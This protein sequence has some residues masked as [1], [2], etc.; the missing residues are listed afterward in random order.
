MT[1]DETSEETSDEEEK[2]QGRTGDD[3]PTIP[4][5]PADE[6]VQEAGPPRIG[7]DFDDRWD[8]VRG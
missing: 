8:R 3:E 2:R 5:L 1:S 6:I 7:E 4:I